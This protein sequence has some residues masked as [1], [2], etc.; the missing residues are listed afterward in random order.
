MYEQALA[1]QRELGNKLGIANALDGFGRVAA[2]QGR[3]HRAFRLAGA[4]AGLREA[5]R[6]EL[7]PTER[8]APD[9]SFERAPRAG[10]RGNGASA[11]GGAGHGARAGHSVCLRNAAWGA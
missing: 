2:A 11:R 5:V 3:L 7:S 10:P 9:R 1:I 8:A 4:A 6:A